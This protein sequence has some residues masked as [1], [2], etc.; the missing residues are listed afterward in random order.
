[1]AF[2]ASGKPLPWLLWGLLAA[3]LLIGVIALFV[4]RSEEFQGSTRTK[5]LLVGLVFTLVGTVG[6]PVF[7]VRGITGRSDAE[8]AARRGTPLVE[9]AI[10]DFHEN[11]G[12][13]TAEVQFQVG[14]VHFSYASDEPT[15]GFDHP[16]TEGGPLRPGLYVR[17][18]YTGS[19]HA[20]TIAKLEIRSC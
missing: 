13:R 4:S 11:P 5:P 15:A 14:D 20:A 2:T 3:A 10:V 8:R 18:V 17:I 12:S 9:G 7:V 1:V 19:P 16:A 6:L